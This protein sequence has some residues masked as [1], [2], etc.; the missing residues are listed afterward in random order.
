MQCTSHGAEGR[1]KPG[2]EKLL[3]AESIFVSHDHELQRGQ[4]QQTDISYVIVCERM[5]HKT[6]CGNLA[7]SFY[8]LIV[9]CLYVKNRISRISE[10]RVHIT[11]SCKSSICNPTYTYTGLS[12]KQCGRLW[13][14]HFHCDCILIICSSFRITRFLLTRV[15]QCVSLQGLDIFKNIVQPW[16]LLDQSLLWL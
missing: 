16:S 9:R 12:Q 3:N 11:L 8:F 1:F 4:L 5:L 10:L 14:M 7:L 2:W 15:G 13:K 6:P